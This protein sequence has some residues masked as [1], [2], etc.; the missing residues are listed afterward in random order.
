M[1]PPSFPPAHVSPR[2]PPGLLEFDGYT[3]ALALL[4][5][6]PG[7]RHAP[8]SPPGHRAASPPDAAA[9]AGTQ[10]GRCCPA[11]LPGAD[12]SG[13]GGAQHGP[14]S[15]PRK[16]TNTTPHQQDRPQKRATRKSCHRRGQAGSEGSA[17]GAGQPE[18]Q[19]SGW[20]RLL[21]GAR[22]LRTSGAARHCDNA[23]CHRVRLRGTGEDNSN[24]A[25]TQG[26]GTPLRLCGSL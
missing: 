13:E 6:L 4:L 16:E 26:P 2:P 5:G 3:D 18:L 23:R 20:T 11:V 12:T 10:R 24:Q 19:S 15:Q 25:G 22:A 7:T 14:A 17:D 8:P 1:M 9:G 21:L